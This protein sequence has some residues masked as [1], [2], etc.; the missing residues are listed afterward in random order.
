MPNYSSHLIF[1]FIILAILFILYQLAGS[2]LT[3]PQLALFLLFY[4]LGSVILTPDLDSKSE[5]LRRCGVACMPYRKLFK[6]RGT[7]HHPLWGVASRI[8]YVALLALIILWAGGAL[9]WRFEI[10]GGSALAFIYLHVKE[11]GIAGAGLFLSN[12]LHIVL[13]KIA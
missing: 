5:A 3:T 9:G 10:D 13:D 4:T 12:M 1:N 2:P 11:I 8:L 7:S 6:H